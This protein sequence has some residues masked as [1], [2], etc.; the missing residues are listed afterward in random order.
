MSIAWKETPFNPPVSGNSRRW[1]VPFTMFEPSHGRM[2]SAE[3]ITTAA[4]GSRSSRST[5]RAYL[6]QLR[7]VVRGKQRKLHRPK[8]SCRCFPLTH[9]EPPFR[10]L[11]EFVN[12]VLRMWWDSSPVQSNP[13]SREKSSLGSK[14]YSGVRLHARSQTPSLMGPGCVHAWS[15]HFG[16]ELLSVSHL[17][18]SWFVS[19]TPPSKQPPTWCP[20][21]MSGPSN[22]CLWQATAAR[23]HHWNSIMRAF[24]PNLSALHLRK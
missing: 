18:K 3:H 8:I 13:P 16:T 22:L 4:L 21:G 6:W 23:D 5:R 7:K 24:L 9:L 10:T 1:M 12:G 19:L 2:E 15:P 20:A 11:Q 14:K 17:G